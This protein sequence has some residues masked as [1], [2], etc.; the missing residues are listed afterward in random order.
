M[1]HI[2]VSMKILPFFTILPLLC[3]CFLEEPG[4]LTK[5]VY[6]HSLR[7]IPIK[8]LWERGI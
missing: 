5:E 6:P 2:C 7:N 8:T 1:I 3:F 4:A